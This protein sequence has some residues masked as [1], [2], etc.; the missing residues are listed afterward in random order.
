M[1]SFF[2]LF[3][4]SFISIYSKEYKSALVA[5]GSGFLGSHM[6]ERLLEKGY[7]VICLDNLQTGSKQNILEFQKNGNFKFIFHDV[8]NRVEL[9][10]PVDEIYNFACAASPPLYQKDP[11]HTLKTNIL[12][13]LHL[14]EIAKKNNATFF[15]AST[16]E[17]YGDPLEHPQKESYRGNVSTTGI[18][19]CYDE[20]KRAAETLCFDFYR[21]Y[22]VSIKVARI[23]NTY[24][25]K[26]RSDDGRVV[27]NFISQAQSK[28]DLTLYGNGQQTRSFCFVSDLIDAIDSFMQTQKTIT[29][30]INLG[31]EEE[32]LVLDLAKLV[33]KKTKSSSKM[34]FYPLPEDDPKVRKPDLSMGRKILGWEPKVG[35]QEGLEKTINYFNLRLK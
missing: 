11:V 27:S 25:P 22:G 20:G 29:G 19:S 30:P 4:L 2:F 7:K 24:G 1:K 26:M 9:D 34:V 33:L 13:T 14:L 28:Q 10:E 32:F 6:C 23:F 15:Q 31:G 8:C 35:L 3:I 17:I 16:S 5:G 21:Q 12:G 18:R